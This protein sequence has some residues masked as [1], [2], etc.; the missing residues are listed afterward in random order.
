M[1]VISKAKINRLL[2]A[3]QNMFGAIQD[4]VSEC[5][6][7]C[8]GLDKKE[9]SILEFIGNSQ[10]IIM[11][12]IA[13]FLKASVSTVTGIVDRLVNKEL[14]LREFSHEDRRI[15]NIT[16]SKQGDEMFR[17]YHDQKTKMCN[18]ILSALDE[19][20]QDQLIELFEKVTTNIT[21]HTLK[22]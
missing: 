3:M 18:A 13:D 5:S 12:D 19:R 10:D 8:G 21:K 22:T 14:L 1:L 9:L 15:I 20:E 11:R 17:L 6:V 4:K 2:T 7:L 16:L